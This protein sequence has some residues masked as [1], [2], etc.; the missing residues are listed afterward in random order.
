MF[1][2]HLF[3]KSDGASARPAKVLD[4]VKMSEYDW[5]PDEDDEDWEVQLCEALENVIPFERSA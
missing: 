5:E 1:T 3:R 2:R 4:E